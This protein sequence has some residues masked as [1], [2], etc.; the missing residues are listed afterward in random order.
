M[1]SVNIPFDEVEAIEIRCACGLGLVFSNPIPEHFK[2]DCSGCGKS[3]GD[4][5]LAVQRF[6]AFRESVTVFSIAK[7]KV[8]FRVE[9]E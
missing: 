5:I 8:S 4:G 6:D 9:S 1:K 2:A 7:N 3:L